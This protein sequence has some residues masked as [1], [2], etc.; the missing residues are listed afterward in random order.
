MMRK[1]FAGVS[2]G[3]SHDFGQEFV[4]VDPGDF[5]KFV[6]GVHKNFSRRFAG[7][8]SGNSQEFN[9]GNCRSSCPVIDKSAFGGFPGAPPEDSQY[10]LLGIRR[11]FCW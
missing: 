2:A 8:P 10:L 4:E 7:G 5:Q 3:N 6:P 9:V 1:S 11:S